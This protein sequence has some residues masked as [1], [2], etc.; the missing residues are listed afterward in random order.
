MLTLRGTVQKWQAA[1]RK[2]YLDD[3]VHKALHCSTSTLDRWSLDQLSWG[4]GEDGS[5]KLVHTLHVEI[6][7]EYKSMPAET[8][9]IKQGPHPF[10][11]NVP[12]GQ[13][14]PLGDLTEHEDC[15]FATLYVGPVLFDELWLCCA[16]GH[17]SPKQISLQVIGVDRQR[18]RLFWDQSRMPQL[19]ITEFNFSLES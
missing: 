1:F 11:D 4:E 17:A 15:M 10:M 13:R 19:A 18:D 12:D 16:H 9:L 8:K 3:S 14:R 2:S 5:G 6:Y 7:R